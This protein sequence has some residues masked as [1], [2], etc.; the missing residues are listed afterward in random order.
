[1]KKRKFGVD[2]SGRAQA[3]VSKQAKARLTAL[4][5]ACVLLLGVVD[6]LT[7][8]ESSLLL[9]YLLP[10]SAVTWFA[11]GGVG[12]L[13]AVASAVAWLVA[14]LLW[15]VSYSHPTIPYW[16]AMVMLSLFLIVVFLIGR[17]KSL[18]EHLEEKVE[19]RTVALTQEIAERKRAEEALRASEEYFR[20]LIENVLDIITILD[21]EGVIRYESPSVER[22]LGYKPAELIGVNI[23]ELLH[24]D[25][26]SKVN[27]AIKAVAPPNGTP[28]IAQVVEARFRHKDG[29]WRLLEAIGKALPSGL[30]VT[31]IVVNSRDI[32]ERK[33]AEEA[34]QQSYAKLQKALEGTIHTLASAIEMRDPYTAG[35]QRR[36]TQLACAI[37]NEMGLPEE[38]I[39][40]IRMAGLIHDVGKINIPADIL[41]KPGRLTD[42]EFGLIKMHPQVG[43]DILKTVD[44]PWP[45]AQIV[46]QHHERMDGSGY[47]QGLSGEEILVEARILAIA[48]V[49]EAMS[50]HRPYRPAR[51]IDQALEE[52]SQNRGVLYDPKAVDACLKL[53]TEDGFTLE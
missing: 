31:G 38:Q 50:S 45:V 49:V 5:F 16:N 15:G 29:S 8:A 19:E 20:T 25:D 1:M 26:V 44:F 13:I 2:I 34:L 39:E 7:G 10:I 53:F 27:V 11:G 18:N 33:R 14:D 23:V 22:V 9:F 28:G 52:I 24:P 51:G 40:G 21:A 6:Y 41:S 36:V 4:G 12:V 47:P 37:A 46:L 30:P 43:H 32:T 42:L 3:L 17:F 48:D 35:H